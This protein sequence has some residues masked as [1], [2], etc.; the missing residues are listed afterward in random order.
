MIDLACAFGEQR[1]PINPRPCLRPL[2]I[3]RNLYNSPNFSGP[4]LIPHSSCIFPVSW[5]TSS[6]FNSAE[7]RLYG[8]F[9]HHHSS[10]LRA[11]ITGVSSLQGHG[12]DREWRVLNLYDLRIGDY[13]SGVAAGGSQFVSRD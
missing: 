3:F 1:R 12:I 5:P 10:I 9:A 6:Q 11:W 2:Q 7:R 4:V 8:Y 13:A